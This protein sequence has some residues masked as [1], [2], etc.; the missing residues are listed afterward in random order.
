MRLDRNSNGRGKYALI[1]NRR[2]DELRSPDTKELPID[3]EQ[4]LKT[5]AEAG[6][7]DVGDSPSAEF[8][9]MRLKDRFAG[10]ALA[11]YSQHA[12]AVDLEYAH[13]V[14]QL[15]KRSGMAHPLCRNPD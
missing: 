6:V 7:L 1:K 2:L 10:P 4:A 15:A 14:S 9:V 11:T 5:L 12:A 13:E 3:I 8:F